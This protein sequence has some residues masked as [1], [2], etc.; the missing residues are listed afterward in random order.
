M[1]KIDRDRQ[2]NYRKSTAFDISSWIKEHEKNHSKI[3]KW[4]I[5]EIESLKV[6]SLSKWEAAFVEGLYNQIVIKGK[7]MT[8]KQAIYFDELLKRNADS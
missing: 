8:A 3:V 2:R 6:E 7:N 1:N 5:S 4:F